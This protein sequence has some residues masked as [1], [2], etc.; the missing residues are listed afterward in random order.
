MKNTVHISDLNFEHNNWK[1]ELAFQK[2]ELK[3]FQNRLDEVVVRWTDKGVLSQIEQFQNN[4][5]R[6]NEVHDTLLHDLNE[7]ANELS[8]FAQDHPVAIDHVHFTDHTEFRDKMDTQRTIF[9]DF[10]KKFFRF[11]TETM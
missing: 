11:L 5:I 4:I 9:A 6:Y 3:I 2:D 7:H 10:K 1:Q 8:Q